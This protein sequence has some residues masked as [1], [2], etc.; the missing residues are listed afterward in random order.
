MMQ[1]PLELRGFSILARALPQRGYSHWDPALTSAFL[2]KVGVLAKKGERRDYLHE[3]GTFRG[4]PLH[5]TSTS[6]WKSLW[7]LAAKFLGLSV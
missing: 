7:N 1:K 5:F 6:N 2:C 3:P 4:L